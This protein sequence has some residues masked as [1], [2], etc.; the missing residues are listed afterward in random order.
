M[1]TMRGRSFLATY[2]A[3]LFCALALALPSAAHAQSAPSEIEVRVTDAAG[4]PLADARVFI[5]GAL[6]GSALTPHDGRVRFTDVEPGLYRLRV[7]LSGY[8]GVDADDVEALAGER[9]V[10]EITLERAA[11]KKPAPPNASATPAPEQ[12]K[13]I[14]RVRARPAVSIS[15]VDVDEGNPIRRISENLSDA[16]DKI[17][18]ISVTQDQQLGT[19]SIS[20][21]NMDPSQTLASA[22]GTPLLGGG[23]A[24]LQSVAADL[25]TGVSVSSG[26][27]GTG[28]GGAVNFR[29]LEPTKTWQTQAS[30]SYGTYE[31]TAAQLSLSGSY[32]KLGIALQHAVRGGDSILTGL[33]FEDT[34]GLDYV[35]DGAF[36]RTGDFF[37]LRYPVGHV[38]LTGGYL[39]GTNRSSPLCDQFVTL[40]P[41]GYGP[42][43]TIRGTSG[44]QTFGMQGQIGNVIVNVNAFS[45]AYGYVDSELGRVVGGIPSPYRSDLAGH[46]AGVFTYETVAIHRHTLILNFGTFAGRGHT[47]AS[48]RFQG[49][50]ENDSRYGYSVLADTVK[51][52]DRWSATLGY[53]QN[54]SLAQSR[55]AADVNVA[56]TPSKQETISFG[57]GNY[58]NGSEYRAGGLFA[59]PAAAQYDCGASEVRVNGPSDVPAA[60]SQSA[61]SF[62]YSRRGRRG[63]VRVN[64]YDV[65]DRNGTL[66]AQFPLLA[67]PAGA[68]PATYVDQLAAFWHSGAICGAQ[69]FDPSRIYVAEQI[70]GT[71]V[72]YR[73]FDASGQ[74]VLG[75]AV[76]ALP[77]Y[78][79]NGAVLAS[80][81]PRLLYAGSPYAVGA[82]LPFRPLHKA[83]LLIDAQQRKAALEWVV[84]GTW[85][86]ANN[87]NALGSYVQ[88]AA[89]V[90][91]TARRGRL[92]LFANNLFNADTGLFSTN[93]FAQ[94]LSLRG[95]GTYVPVPTLLAPRSYTLLY[96][97]RAGRLR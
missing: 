71:T 16:L 56:L 86:S 90:T 10:V 35:H 82:Q 13:E 27:N 51:F 74:I 5:S 60:G 61:A 77:S 17:G 39:G 26:N 44:Q 75:R 8:A 31:H 45:N 81:D 79:V 97:V 58:G 83:G 72:R 87:G 25:S 37:K 84:N 38:T 88:V 64:A 46:G 20:L 24:T 30:A 2:V 48:G 55:R 73:G 53:G 4:K 52:S 3:V 50:T 85:V 43:G 41:C 67:L 33:R 23:A 6:T 76:I 34:S 92:T 89:G 66:Q 95:G 21:R 96:S 22:G 93:E 18:G 54:V 40:L 42:G 36:D 63:S 15:S 29:T 14:G 57:L 91:W 1:S 49:T 11:A 68:V 7:V 12:L 28:I 62:N 9:K 80:A 78:S 32:H 47:I 70:A 59:D 65:T 94:P 69:A 19:L